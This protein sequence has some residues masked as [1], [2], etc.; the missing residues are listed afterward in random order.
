MPTDGQTDRQIEDKTT[1]Q[2]S[3][4]NKSC[5]ECQQDVRKIERQADRQTDGVTVTF[6]RRHSNR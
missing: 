4:Q 6:A 5:S 1:F 2:P 3:Y